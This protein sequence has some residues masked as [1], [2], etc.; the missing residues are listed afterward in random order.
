MACKIVSSILFFCAF[1][2]YKAPTDETTSVE[3]KISQ[4]SN[5]ALNDEEDERK[6]K[7]TLE[8]AVKSPNSQLSDT[9][10]SSTETV[11]VL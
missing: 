6:I 8:G 7:E 9:S 11:T 3:N 2:F 5:F 10:A 1:W 4:F